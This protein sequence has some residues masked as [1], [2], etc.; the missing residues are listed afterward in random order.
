ML[1]AVLKSK[2]ILSFVIIFGTISFPVESR[3]CISVR[4]RRVS[5]SVC[6]D[7]LFVP[8][9]VRRILVRGVNAPLT[10]EAKKILKI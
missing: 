1:I 3:R 4:C 8:R 5:G 10:P 9:N 7:G 6:V 2:F